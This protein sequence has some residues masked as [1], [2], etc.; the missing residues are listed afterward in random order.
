MLNVK[1]LLAKIL[2]SLAPAAGTTTIT[3]STGTLNSHQ[4]IRCGKIRSLRLE[5]SKSSATSAGSN[6]FAGTI[7]N[8]KDIPKAYATGCGYYQSSAGIMQVETTGDITVRI[9]GAQLA[10]NS[11]MWISVTYIAV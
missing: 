3:T 4:I 9:V 6:L 10:A 8:A 5:V 1:K 7:T 11:K 2:D